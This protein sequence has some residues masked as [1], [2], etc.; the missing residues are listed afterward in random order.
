MSG[1]GQCPPLYVGLARFFSFFRYA[2]ASGHVHASLSWCGFVRGRQG[3]WCTGSRVGRPALE[4]SIVSTSFVEWPPAS[5]P[6]TWSIRKPA[7]LEPD[8]ASQGR[9]GKKCEVGEPEN[10]LAQI[11]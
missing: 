7:W 6:T 9:S 2:M 3:A 10:I 8:F 4:A 5:L 1:G 11:T